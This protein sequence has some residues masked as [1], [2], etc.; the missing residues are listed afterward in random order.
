MPTVPIARSIRV[1]GALLSLAILPRPALEA[2]APVFRD[3][4]TV[5]PNARFKAGGLHRT[6]FGTRY[7]ELWTTPVRVPVLDLASFG[8]GLTPTQRGGGLQTKSLRLRGGD[9]KE[10]QFRSIE[11]DPS[12]L[13]PEDLRDTF[14]EDLL[15]DQMS[16]GHPAGAVVVPPLLEAAGLLHPT[17]IIV[18]MPDDARLGQFRREFAGLLGTI[19]ERPRGMD[20]GVG[21][22][23]ASEVVSTDDLEERLDR[24]PAVRV[25]TREYLLARLF[26][27]FIGDWD[28]HRDQWR[29]ALMPARG[30]RGR[31]WRPIPRDR[32]QAFVRYDGFMLSQA[33]RTAPQ[34]LNFGPEYG[35]IVGHTWNGRDVDRRILTDLEAPVFDSVARVLAS[36]MTDQVIINSVRRMPREF[37]ALDADR[38]ARTLIAR[39]DGIDGMARSYYR[40]LAARVDVWGT[41]KADEAK[42]TRNADGS[43]LVTLTADGT[44]YYRRRFDSGE[45]EEVRL[46][47]HGGA[48]RLTVEGEGRG[49]PAV[50]AVGGG[51]DDHSA[52]TARSGVKLYDERGTNTADGA[53]INPKPWNPPRDTASNEPPPRDWGKKTL[54]MPLLAVGPDVGVL[55]GWGGFTRWFGFRHLP[56][57]RRA[58]YRFIYSTGETSGRLSLGLTWYAENSRSQVKLKGLASGIEVLRWYGF[59]NETPATSDRSFNRLNQDEVSLN[60][61]WGYRWSE[62]NELTIGPMVKWSNTDLQHDRN[63][64]RFIAVDAPYGVEEF[65]MTALEAQLSLDSRDIP[66]FA[67]RGARLSL[68]ARVAPELWDVVETFG[69]F[70]G[71]GSFT[72]AP[73]GRWQPSLNFMAGG[74]WSFGELPFF[75]APGLGGFR[76]LRGYPP[77]RFTGERTAYGSAELRLPLTR[78]RLWVPGQQGV[79][80]FGDAGRVWVDGEDSNELHTS[81]GGGVWLSFAGRGNVLAAGVGVPS[82]ATGSDDTARFFLGF[83]FPY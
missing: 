72:L 56:A 9:G 48:D 54:T 70:R 59:G 13:L 55:V 20:D 58:D 23:G 12:G 52:I 21:F 1:A 57:E 39:R 50:R 34:L 36:R 66:K 42:V 41:D 65:G 62:G 28:R 82:K 80:G 38:L 7:R 14:A 78:L 35:D 3:S 73:S 8:G 5:V 6:F 33:R 26:D 43:T 10:Y 47:L 44:T 83:G 4:V 40:L 31:S 53:G 71:E 77:N 49:S 74:A 81:F 51:G 64:V 27:L 16:S 75:E 32:D 22:E 76:T 61:S 11:K 15:Q 46:Y 17:P 18:Q 24:D 29:W 37:H 69:V 79:F 19:E 30:G 63:R 67:T 60:L 2:Q 45:T 68:E 25:D